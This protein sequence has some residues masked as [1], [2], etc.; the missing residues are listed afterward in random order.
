M[1]CQYFDPCA[2]GADTYTI[3]MPKYTFGRGCLREA[4]AR[5]IVEYPLTKS[6]A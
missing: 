5:A 2:G 1:G 3:A 4:G 6:V